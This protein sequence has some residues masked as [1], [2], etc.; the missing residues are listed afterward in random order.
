M[1]FDSA[2]LKFWRRLKFGFPSDP[3][4]ASSPSVLDVENEVQVAFHSCHH[5]NVTQDRTVGLPGPISSP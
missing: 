5:Q 3:N 4:A 2:D 1:M